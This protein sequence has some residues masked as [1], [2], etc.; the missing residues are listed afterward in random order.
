MRRRVG[1][2]DEALALGG[3]V[4]YAAPVAA[5]AQNQSVVG[6]NKATPEETKVDDGAEAEAEEDEE[7]IA[8]KAYRPAKLKYGVDHPYPVVENATLDAVAPPDVTYNLASEFR[9]PYRG[10][11]FLFWCPRFLRVA[12]FR[13]NFR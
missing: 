1:G 13:V 11:V 8:Y 2:G 4:A 12:C 7:E 9:I 10:S 6:E 5:S 3:A